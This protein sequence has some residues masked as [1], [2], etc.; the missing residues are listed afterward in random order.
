MGRNAANIGLAMVAKT[1]PKNENHV[2]ELLSNHIKN[3]KDIAQ[4]IGI[5]TLRGKISGW[6]LTIYNPKNKISGNRLLL[7]GDAAGLINPLSGDG[8]QYAL[9]S[10]RWAA[11]CIINCAEKNDFS[12]AAANAYTKK[13]KKSWLM[14]LHYLTCL[15]SLEEIRLLNRYGWK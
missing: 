13:L 15:F 2:K 1:L 10:A 9:L 3:N 14:I 12:S 11:E 6:P 7:L 5:G 8:I 4:R